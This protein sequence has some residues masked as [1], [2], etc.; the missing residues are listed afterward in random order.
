MTTRLKV[1]CIASKEEADMAVKYGASAL[2]LVSEMPSGPGPINDD[3]IAQIAQAAP[4][5]ISTFLLTCRTEAQEIVEQL[6]HCRTSTVQLVDS[7]ETDVYYDIRKE[8]PQ[9]KIVQVVHVIDEN[10]V[11]DVIEISKH[12]DGVL[13]DSGNPNLKVKELGGTGR[14]HNWEISR[15][16]VEAV[17]IPVLL[18]GGINPENVK[19]A[20]KL[21]KPFGIDLCTGIRTND[22]LDE[23][24]LKSLT[25]A[26]FNTN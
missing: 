17:N 15:K 25:H 21:V 14:V 23:N 2:G 24:K 10:A 13:L 3:L 11:N 26:M 4:P 9:V 6:K 12:V 8:L 5:M 7:V 20:V 1:C 18:A 22:A 19:D 16:I